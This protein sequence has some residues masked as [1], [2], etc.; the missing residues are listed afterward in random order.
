MSSTTAWRRHTLGAISLT[1]IAIGAAI[2]F[3][4]DLSDDWV[5][6]QGICVKVGT[7][8]LMAWVAYPQLERLSPGK[9]AT[10]LILGAAIVFRPQLIPSLAR[11]LILL[12]PL[13]V[14]IWLL[15]IPSKGRSTH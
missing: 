10:V 5:F 15:R 9:M 3:L 12:A 13:L 14:I 4:P 1:L 6:V 11:I 8:L 7:V 2:W